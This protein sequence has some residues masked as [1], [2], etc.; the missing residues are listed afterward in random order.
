MKNFPINSSR[1]TLFIQTNSPG[2][3]S[4]WVYPICK[5]IE[6]TKPSWQVVIL[7][8]PCQ[9]ATGQEKKTALTFPNVV[10]ALSPKETLKWLVSRPWFKKCYHPAAL[11]FLGGDPLYTQLLSKKLK[12]PAIAYTN[13][14][15]KIGR[16]FH[17]IFYQNDIGDLMADKHLYFTF[18]KED[19]FK[20][21]FIQKNKRYVLFLSGSR[22]N[23]AK[24][25]SPFIIETIKELKKRHPT[26]LYAIQQSPFLSE[27]VQTIQ[28][29]MAKKED[30]PIIKADLLSAIQQA[31]WIVTLPGSN[32]ADCRYQNKPFITILPLNRPDLIIFDGLLGLAGKLPLIGA[33]L[34]K[35]AITLI[36]RNDPMVSISNQAFKKRVTPEIVGTFTPKELA[37][38][39]L[40]YFQDEKAEKQII[41]T[42]KE[43][44]IKKSASTTI[45]ETITT[46]FLSPNFENLSTKPTKKGSVN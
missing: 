36:K 46:L 37:N 21:N 7:L 22:P 33:L 10:L 2:E 34:K 17:T 15:H 45:I 6:E 41:K 12:I 3:L 16:F 35:I 31:K 26:E 20:T 39:L 32:N 5:K 24:A 23:Q 30:I 25:F 43:T 44:P 29:Q 42:F 18:K 13:H 38:Q 4:N 8:T 1:P 40:S 19:F 14:T 28:T 9:Y 11:L 27:E